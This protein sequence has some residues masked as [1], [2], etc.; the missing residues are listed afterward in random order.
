MKV[1]FIDV[2]STNIKTAVNT[3]SGLTAYYSVPFPPPLSLLP[4]YYEVSLDAIVSTVLSLIEGNED[5]IYIA[6]Q[7]HGYILG[8]RH[9]AVS[10]YISWRDERAGSPETSSAVYSEY[11]TSSKPNLPRFGI[12]FI[13]KHDPILFNKADTLY[14]LGSYLSFVLTGVNAAHI[15]DLAPTGYYNILKRTV[16]SCSLRLPAALYEVSK[17]GGCG[18]ISVFAPVGDQQA[19]VYGADVDNDSYIVNIGTA[20]QA[21]VLHDGFVA[22]EYESRPYFDGK[23]LCTVTRLMGGMRIEQNVSAVALAADYVAAIEKL[24]KRSKIAV[25]GGGALYHK[26]ILS[27]AFDIIGKEYKFYE[28]GGALNGLEKLS[29]KAVIV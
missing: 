16:D 19:A 3:G 7:M 13:K 9:G 29:I 28:N 12:D 14:T 18:N 23:T 4:P 11:G 26:K 8:D 10:E 27:A 6:V 2:G 20:A 5:A 1:R 22:G 24:P 15:T 17:V 25:I 21:C